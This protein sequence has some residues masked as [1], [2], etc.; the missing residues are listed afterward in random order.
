MYVP[1]TLSSSAAIFSLPSALYILADPGYD[2]NRLY[3]HSK[4]TLG[5]DLVCSLERYESILKRET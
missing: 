4:K 1:L 5:M 2:D 3:K